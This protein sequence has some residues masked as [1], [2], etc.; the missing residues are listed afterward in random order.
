M[1]HPLIYP[2]G[3]K[4]KVCIARNGVT[5][6]PLNTLFPFTEVLDGADAFISSR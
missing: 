1:A 5:T 2:L 4:A 3:G 6:G